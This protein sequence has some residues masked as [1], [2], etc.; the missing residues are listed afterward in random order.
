MAFLLQHMK[1]PPENLFERDDLALIYSI[2]KIK[3]CFS[4]QTYSSQVGGVNTAV[5]IFCLTFEASIRFFTDMFRSKILD[6]VLWLLLVQVLG[7]SV[8]LIMWSAFILLTLNN[9]DLFFY[10]QT[11]ATLSPIP[12]FLQWLLPKL[13][14]ADTFQENML[15]EEEE[16]ALLDSSLWVS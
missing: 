3:S 1:L 13:A 2:H 15:E 11:F 14:S 9:F 16:T 6:F 8:T 4:S 12:G 5:L 10:K 7:H